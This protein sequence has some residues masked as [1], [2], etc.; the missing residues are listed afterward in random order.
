MWSHYADKHRG[1]CLGFDIPEQFAIPVRYIENRTAVRFVDGVQSLGVEPSFAFELMCSKHSA[2]SYEKEVRM[3]I[4]LEESEEDSGLFF[5]PFGAELTLREVI[6]GHRCIVSPSEI[7]TALGDRASS[8]K[9]TKARLAFR[10]FRVVTDR[11]RS[12]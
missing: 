6:L 10:S 2:W 1:I 3:F 4:G 11:S 8:V 12:R 7:A 9:V 5:Y